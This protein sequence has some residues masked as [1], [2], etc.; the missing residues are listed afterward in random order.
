MRKH[1]LS[2]IFK[3]LFT[4]IT[5]IILLIPVLANAETASGQCGDNVTW[6]LSENG[7]MTISGAG[8]MWDFRNDLDEYDYHECPWN[9]LRQDITRVVFTKGI[10]YVG[11]DAF[12]G[13]GNLT[14]VSFADTITEIGTFAFFF[15]EKLG[16][17]TLPPGLQSIR[18]Q[19]FDSTAITVLDIPG[20]VRFVD[21]G[22]CENC[23][24]LTSVIFRKRKEGGFAMGNGPFRNCSA[25]ER[26]DV[27]EGH[28]VL[29]SFDGALYQEKMLI[30]YPLGRRSS[31][32]KV[33]AGCQSIF[34]GAFENAANLETLWLPRS[35]RTVYD[36]AFYNCNAL[37]AVTYE[38]NEDWWKKIAIEENNGPLMNAILSFEKKL[39]E[40]SGKCGKSAAW[41][42]SGEGVLTI[43]GTGRMWDFRNGLDEYDYHECPWAEWT[44]KGIRSVIIENGITYIG[45]SAFD[46]LNT[47]ESVSLPNTLDAIVWGAFLGCVNLKAVEYEGTSKNWK[48]ID[49][50]SANEALMNSRI[51]FRNIPRTTIEQP[52]KNINISECDI[53]VKEYT[54]TGKVLKPVPAVK[55]NGVK[56]R[57]GTDYTVSYKN[58]KN[59]GLGTVIIRGMGSCT[60]SVKVTFR[61]NPK[62]TTISR[63]TG[64]VN[65]VVITWKKQT[66][67]VS[68]YQI[69]Y[70]TKK[71]FSNAKRVTIKGA[72]TKKTTIRKLKAKQTFYVRIRTYKSTK[73][74]RYYS[75]WSKYKRI[76]TK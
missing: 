24:K 45:A 41:S 22:I 60:G 52:S 15:A 59:V 65:K 37:K 30:Q 4:L 8:R 47:L 6:V 19:A 40:M 33:E 51:T 14:Q 55:Y 72:K 26:I 57:N 20:S 10:T 44:D 43:S 9:H 39:P 21:G 66:K 29:H 34:Q 76:R 61:I 12:N 74:K 64:G 69:Q 48:D 23:K 35:L 18:Q 70:S 56:L 38:G 13:C 1:H 58:N 27:E 49:I 71:N 5:C 2:V 67:Q 17:F 63:V 75:S 46:S 32:Y 54:Y 53:S 25:L 42:L 68:G 16:N 50:G 73:G 62:A 31:A 28:N 36:Y 11:A 7:V 3:T